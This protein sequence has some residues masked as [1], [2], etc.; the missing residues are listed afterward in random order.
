MSK[1]QKM[2][3]EEKAALD[4]RIVKLGVFI[5][6]G[7]YQALNSADRALLDAQY[8]VMNEYSKIL[9]NRLSRFGRIDL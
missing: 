3:V 7:G 8:R 1:V 2:V 5:A 6:G 4:D 9:G